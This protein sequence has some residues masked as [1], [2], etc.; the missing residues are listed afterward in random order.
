[1]LQ[2]TPYTSTD[3]ESDDRYICDP[4]GNTLG[5]EVGTFEQLFAIPPKPL[6]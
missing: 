2:S 6:H 4:C 5:Y 3:Q 1:M